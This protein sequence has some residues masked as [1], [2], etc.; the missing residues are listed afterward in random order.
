MLPRPRRCPSLAQEMRQRRTRERLHLDTQRALPSWL[1]SFVL[2]LLLMVLLGSLMIPQRAGKYAET[3]ILTLSFADEPLEQGQLAVLETAPSA[4]DASDQHTAAPVTTAEPGSAAGIESAAA[5]AQEFEQLVGALRQVMAPARLVTGQEPPRNRTLLGP[6]SSQMS[7]VS[8]SRN[9][10]DGLPIQQPQ[11]D[12]VVDRFIQ[13]DIGQLPGREGELARRQFD[14]LGPDA[15]PALVRGLNKAAY[16]S[17]SCPILVISRKL[18]TEL[19][20]SGDPALV[21]FALDNV[22]RDVPDDAPYARRLQKLKQSWAA[23]FKKDLALTPQQAALDLKSRDPESRLTAA[24]AIAQFPDQFSDAT[25]N[26]LAWSLVRMLSDPAPRTRHLA[27][28]ALVALAGG[29]DLGSPDGVAAS[30]RQKVVGRWYRHFDPDRYE[31]MAQ[32][33]LRS[34]RSLESKPGRTAATKFYRKLITDFPGTK[35]AEEASTRLET[36]SGSPLQPAR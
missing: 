7:S 29:D 23:R 13:Y 30:E 24:A 19:S 4:A 1:S 8:S 20:K 3:L 16:I 25:R 33:L 12:D 27:H 11:F 26:D 2:H 28:Q 10:L 9:A 32:A 14:V 6:L 17:A 36:L 35:A 5:V 31:A 15:I 18:E 34:T 21:Q 22:G